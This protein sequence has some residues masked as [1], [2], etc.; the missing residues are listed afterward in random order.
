[1]FEYITGK[2]TSLQATSAVIETSGIG[3][4]VNVSLN[5]YSLL[6]EGTE[7]KL[8]LHQVIRE[9]AHTLFGFANKGEREMFR[10]L[11]GVNGIGSNTAIVMLSTL[12]Y[13]ELQQA[14]LSENLAALKAVK[15]IGLKTAQRVIIDLKDKLAKTG[16]EANGEGI[17]VSSPNT[18][19]ASMAL[20]MLGFTKKAIEKSVTKIVKE[21]PS[22][23]VENLVK[24]ALKDL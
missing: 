14:I 9:D 22:I 2:L 24:Q 8:F 7:V 11:L 16:I 6:N 17:Q 3:Y 19:E 5:T 20:V 4:F 21:N 18:E 13:N 15:G 12:S 10:L 23:S 1:M